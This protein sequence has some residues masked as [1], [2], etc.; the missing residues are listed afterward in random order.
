VKRERALTPEQQRK[1]A[2][3]AEIKRA[4]DARKE[5]EKEDAARRHAEYL[6]FKEQSQSSGYSSFSAAP[7]VN[8]DEQAKAAIQARIQ[9]AVDA[10][11]AVDAADAARRQ[12]EYLA[13][14]EQSSSPR[15]SS[16]SYSTASY[17]NDRRYSAPAQRAPK[18][19]T[20]EQAAKA[21]VQAKIQAAVDARK[22]LE[23]EEAARRHAEYLAFKGEQSVSAWSWS[24][25]APVHD[26][27][28]SAPAQRAPKP[29]SA[30]DRAKAAIQ[31]K[32]QAAVDAR[33]K[34]EQEAAARRHAEYLAFKEQQSS[35]SYAAPASS[36]WD[37]P[38]PAASS[39]DTP[40]PAASSWDSAP[41]PVAANDPRYS[42]PAKREKR[43]TP[44]DAALAA[45]QAEI[46]KAVDAR[47]AVE[48]EEAARRAA[49]Y[50]REKEAQTNK[51]S[52]GSY[53]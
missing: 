41:A 27:R 37:T 35:S 16:P 14:K 1:A 17:E 23:Q 51:A 36:S 15:S 21:A 26:N 18:P 2:K 31:A 3:A 38:A 52:S 19:V 20:P 8:A 30:E 5:I 29:M 10:R 34:L 9:E 32:I 11:K 4:V 45:R 28:Y 24:S 25:S 40:A 43:V 39:W 6:A 22:K 13:F 12:A 44:A 47:K 33:K 49:D 50:A 7:S 48:A 46:K 53:W 42:S